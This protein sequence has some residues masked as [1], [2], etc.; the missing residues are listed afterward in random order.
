MTE[1]IREELGKLSSPQL[2]DLCSLVLLLLVLSSSLFLG[3]GGKCLLLLA[4]VLLSSLV[5]ERAGDF[6]G[7]VL[8]FECLFECISTNGGSC[9]MVPDHG[10]A[11]ETSLH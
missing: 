2:V 5:G 10:I 7:R 4:M 1:S 6:G 8:R 11:T 3:R 9:F